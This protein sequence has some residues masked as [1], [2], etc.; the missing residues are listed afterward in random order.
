MTR[1]GRSRVDELLVARGLAPSLEDAQI[2]VREGRVHGADR[3][4]E[5]PGESVRLDLV[6]TVKP[7]GGRF[8]SRGGEK[9]DGALRDLDIHPVG[10]RCIDLGAST[11]GFTDCL[12]QRGAVR[13][14]SIDVG[15]GQLHDRLRRDARV[16]SREATDLRTLDVAG[17]RALLGGEW[18][19]V[20]GD[21]SFISLA[22]CL[23]TIGPLLISGCSALLL[24]KPQFELPRDLVPPGGVVADEELEQMALKSVL[25][26]AGA[27]GLLSAGVAESRLRGAD[28]NREYF[29]WLQRP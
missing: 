18:G 22:R 21:L 8:V 3:R 20:V 17:A 19:L 23:P 28:G 16:V 14:L 5:K 1:V 4:Y 27:C 24:V 25:T 7:A 15:R 2:A 26:R 29:V 13:V 9:L 10:L 6:L 11:G 12:L